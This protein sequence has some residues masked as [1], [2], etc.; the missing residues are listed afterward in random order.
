MISPLYVLANQQGDKSVEI[1]DVKIFNI[2]NKSYTGI[3]TREFKIN[4]AKTVL[5]NAVLNK[6]SVKLT[7]NRNKGIDGYQIYHS[8]GKNGK[9]VQ[10]SKVD[11]TKTYYTVK[12]LKE[13]IGYYKIRAYKSVNGKTYYGKFSKGES[14]VYKTNDSSIPAPSNPGQPEENEKLLMK[15]TIGNESFTVTLED[16]NTAKA[17]VRQLPL[18]VNMTELNGNEKF[19]YMKEDLR[20]DTSSNLG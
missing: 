1:T 14:V 13:G 5:N 20:G 19:Y 15:V 10:L 3:V 4:P 2:E 9:F 6:S 12:S 11:A 16:N 18:T 8:R 17:L 7:W